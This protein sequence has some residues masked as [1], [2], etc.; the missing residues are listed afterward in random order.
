M[1][2]AV[3]SLRDLLRHRELIV[4]L[5]RRELFAPF[6]GTAFGVAWS[7]L[8]PLLQMGV[9]LV[10]FSYIF[11]IRMGDAA[12]G[13]LDDYQAYVLS[14]LLPWMAWASLLGTA[15]TTVVNS[16]S[17]VKQAD[18]PAEV[19]PVRTLLVCLLPHLVS[20]GVLLI[21]MLLRHGR[22]SGGVLWLPLLVL[23]QATAMLGMAYVLSALC[24]FARDVKEVITV[25]TAIGIFLTPAFYPPSM[26]ESL[27][28]VLDTLLW[29]NPFTHFVNMYRDALYWGGVRHPGSWIFAVAMATTLLVVGQRGFA[30]LRLFFGNFL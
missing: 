4:G 24:V 13:G 8:H 1:N 6:A 12:T 17:L 9:Y 26:L 11:Q 29:L 30:R 7:L 15:C 25:F 23:V 2:A 3:A 10:V 5:T 18:F 27:P 16:A 21:Y 20:L 19:L 22:L 28:G 14:G